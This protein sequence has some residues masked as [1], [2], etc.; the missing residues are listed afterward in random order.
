[1]AKDLVGYFNKRPRVGALSTSDKKGHVDSAI[2]GSIRLTDEHTAVMEIGNSTTL[3]N[4]TENPHAVFTIIEAAQALADW[5]GLRVYL[6]LKKS[7]TE[8]NALE[9]AREELAKR[10]GA[11][12]AKGIY[13]T[14]TF[15]VT[16]VRPLIDRGQTWEDSI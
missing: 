9:H 2:F 10:A 4:L 7:E 5:K 11:A 12:A 13:A 3:K 8:G 6:E 1:M 16:K 14:L 15:E